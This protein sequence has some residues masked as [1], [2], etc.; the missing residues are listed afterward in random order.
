M[1][2]YPDVQ[3]KAQ[4]EIDKVVGKN[5]LPEFN[6]R[7][8]MPYVEAMLLETMRWGIVTPLGRHLVPSLFLYLV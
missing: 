2:N 6:D 3:R 8:S 5:R 4:D 7:P 1:V